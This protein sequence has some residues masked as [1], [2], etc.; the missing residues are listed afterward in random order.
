MAERD[1]LEPTY[2]LIDRILRV[3]HG[4]LADFGGA[5]YDG[6]FSLSLE[7]AQRPE[8]DYVAEQI[9][10]RA[11]DTYSIWAA[12]GSTAPVRA[13]TRRDWGR[14]HGRGHPEH[15]PIGNPSR[16]NRSLYTAT[17]RTARRARARGCSDR[18]S[19][20]ALS[21]AI[22]GEVLE[23]GVVSELRWPCGRDTQPRPDC[24]QR[25]TCATRREVLGYWF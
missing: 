10:I 4:E 19:R 6:D 1:H 18:V 15:G 11:G 14:R 13:R 17:A 8:H 7:E 21:E 24:H 20:V 23:F 12:A 3:S 16:W 9:D 22:P 25:R 5:K 2:S